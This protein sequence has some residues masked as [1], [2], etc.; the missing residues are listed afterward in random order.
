MVE[1]GVQRSPAEARVKTREHGGFIAGHSVLA[2]DEPTQPTVPEGSI[3]RYPNAREAV[4][5]AAE[6]LI[7]PVPSL[8]EALVDAFFEH[9]YHSYPVVE[10]NEVSAPDSSILL[11]QAVY[12]AASLMRHGPDNLKLSQS[13]YEKV[14]T[15][16]YLNYEP[17][18]I[19]TL[20]AL[21]LLSCWSVKPPDKM[22]LDGPWYWTGVASRA[23]LQLGLHQESTYTNHPQASSLRRIF[24]HLHVCLA[25]NG[26]SLGAGS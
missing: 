6:A 10:P 1:S 13:L 12:L 19:S 21:C 3:A 4:L 18:N 14:K 16:I 7:L 17:D 8:R 9:V 5:A 24:W 26:A 25:L 22:S 20:K 2:Y 11:Q 15:L 23:A